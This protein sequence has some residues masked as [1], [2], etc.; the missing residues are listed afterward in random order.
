MSISK[1]LKTAI[2]DAGI[3]QTELSRRTGLSKSSI[4]QYVSGTFIPPKATL[5]VLV[6]ALERV[7]K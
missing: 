3:T 7:F 6:K 5:E 4:S 2:A 1:Q